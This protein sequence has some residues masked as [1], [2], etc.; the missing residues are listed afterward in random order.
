MRK[1]FI[2]CFIF[3]TISLFSQ[4]DDGQLYRVS[5]RILED[6]QKTPLEFATITFTD[7]NS[8]DIYRVISSNKGYFEIELK[9]ADYSIVVSYISYINA[10]IT[11]SN[12]K[13]DTELGTIILKSDVKALEEITVQGNKDQVVLKPNTIVYNLEKD[14]STDASSATEVLSN[15]PTL[16][17]DENGAIYFRGSVSATVLINGKTSG[18]DVNSIPA[19]SIERIEVISNP[20][21]SY[22]A[23]DLAIVNIVLKKGKDEGL[24]SSIMVSGGYKEDY[25]LLINVSNKTNKTN[26]YTNFSY[27]NRLRAKVSDFNTT[28][29]DG[30]IAN[31]NMLENSYNEEGSKVYYGNIGLDYYIS[32]YVTLGAS[33]NYSKIDTDGALEGH[34][35][36][37]D[38]NNNLLEINERNNTRFFDNEI[39]EYFL[40]F[41]SNFKNGNVLTLNFEYKKDAERYENLFVNSNPNFLEPDFIEYNKLKNGRA[42]LKYQSNSDHGTFTV[43][44]EGDFGTIPFTYKTSEDNIEIDYTEYVNSVYTEYEWETSK[45]YYGFGLRTEFTDTEIDYKTDNTKTDKIYENFFPT[46]YIERYLKDNKSLSL[47]YNR[48]II[49][50]SYKDLQPF[51]HKFSESNSYMGN[52]DLNPSF[53]DMISLTYAY[54]GSKVN[55]IPSLFFNKYKDYMQIVTLEQDGPTGTKFVNTPRNIGYLN[56]YGL[57]TVMTYNAAKWIDFTLNANIFQLHQEG[58]YTYTG[59]NNETITLD[60]GNKNITGTF[61]LLTK[62]NLSETLSLQSKVQHHLKSIGAQSERLARTWANFS[63]AQEL[64]DGNGTLSLTASDV[65]NTFSLIERNRFDDNYFMEGSINND[66]QTVILSFAYRFNQSKKSR[67]I[68]FSK[69]EEI[70]KYIP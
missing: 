14:I 2:L 26:F 27:F 22:R 18:I 65:F 36:W 42:R 6:L 44:Y 47:S 45:M 12:L 53:A 21:A 34:T 52:A 9:A 46:V 63:I 62:I 43:G 4:N 51:E 40:D 41:E 3:T 7:Q 69:K 60:Y 39:F 64:F 70:E 25:G 1:I 32:D 57:N 56:Y 35:E 55:I 54:Y 49:R 66:F 8:K 61:G 38:S 24:T 50:P 29:F 33:M 23:S 59:S 48:G 58:T 13:E 15:I 67:K 19:S 16:T 28:F 10:E 5:G 31:S 17:A 68:D 37:F 30:A 20:G 11:L